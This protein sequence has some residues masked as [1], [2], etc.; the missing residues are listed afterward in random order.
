LFICYSG[1]VEK[2][3]MSAIPD[4]NSPF[5]LRNPENAAVLAPYLKYKPERSYNNFHG[6][7]LTIDTLFSEFLIIS[8]LSESSPI[9]EMKV[10]SCERP[11]LAMHSAEL[12]PLPPS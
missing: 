3:S 1:R 4:K 2:I 12:R 5:P 9:E 7:L 8:A 11:S 6:D 10:K